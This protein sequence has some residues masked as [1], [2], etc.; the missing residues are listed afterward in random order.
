MNAS[1][2]PVNCNSK[3]KMVSIIEKLNESRCG[4]LNVHSQ[5]AY[6]VSDKL[7]KKLAEVLDYM[8]DIRLNALSDLIQEHFV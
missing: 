4:K 2:K 5:I 3:M 6:T 8:I 7:D 1:K